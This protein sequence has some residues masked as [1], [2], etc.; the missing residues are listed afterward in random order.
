MG[1]LRRHG[2]VCLLLV[3]LIAASLWGLSRFF[4]PFS[5]S[6][7]ALLAATLLFWITGLA[8]C[9]FRSEFPFFRKHSQAIGLAI[10]VV[11]VV[12]LGLGTVAEIF[13]LNWFSWL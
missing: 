3:V 6:Q 8:C 13:E 2:E 7:K 10:L 9:L 11:Y 4:A 12:V 1:Y 5:F